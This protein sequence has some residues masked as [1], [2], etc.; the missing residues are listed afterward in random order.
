MPAE[1]R[2]LALH[3]GHL[4]EVSERDR[5]FVSGELLVHLGAASPADTWRKRLAEMEA[6]G[7]TEVAYQ[8][9]GPDI[10]HELAAF[11][12]MARG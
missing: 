12:A 3:T 4:V 7:A 11:V 2:H 10:R 9:A 5:P 8:P 6:A 1:I